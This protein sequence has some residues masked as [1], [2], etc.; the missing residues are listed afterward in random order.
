MN[1]Q[2][3]RF[4]PAQQCVLIGHLLCA[5][6]RAGVHLTDSS[7][8]RQV[9]LL[10]HFPEEETEDQRGRER[11]QGHRAGV[12]AGSLESSTLALSCN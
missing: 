12:G 6:L 7:P 10:S 3:S 4:I 9:Q 5:R 1:K 2:G 11:A 8:A